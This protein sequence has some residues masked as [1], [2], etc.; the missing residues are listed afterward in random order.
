MSVVDYSKWQKMV[1]E[2]SDSDED[3]GSRPTV[4][5]FDKPQSVTFGGK[6]TPQVTGVS[7]GHSDDRPPVGSDGSRAEHPRDPGE[8]AGTSQVGA[9]HSPVTDEQL[10]ENGAKVLDDTGR[11][12]YVW[13]QTRAEVVA[14]I[15]VPSGTRAKDITVLLR[16]KPTTITDGVADL[17]RVAIRGSDPLLDGELAFPAKLDEEVDW[18]LKDFAG[19]CV[20]GEVEPPQDHVK[21]EVGSS[22]AVAELE[23]ASSSGDISL[24]GRRGVEVFLRKH[25]PVLNAAIWWKSL[26]RGDPE[27]DI[28]NL[29][30]RAKNGHQSA[31]EEAMTMFKARVA[32]RKARGRIQ[33]DVAEH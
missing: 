10:T 7:R 17:L 9:T 3:E 26:L 12:R 14:V 22:P 19:T 8:D 25:S 33:I 5:A 21:N 13:R 20:S 27:I 29:K 32:D 16:A 18:E 6:V 2:M 24:I 15:P 23:N 31:W 11:L 1:S 30:G 28:S 4:T